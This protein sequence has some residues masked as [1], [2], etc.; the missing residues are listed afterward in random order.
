MHNV[1]QPQLYLRAILN[2]ERRAMNRS[3]VRL[4]QR[5]GGLIPLQPVDDSYDFTRHAQS[6][7]TQAQGR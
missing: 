1:T 2:S 4:S 5:E 7:W 6:C 3:K